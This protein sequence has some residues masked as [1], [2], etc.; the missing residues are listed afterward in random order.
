MSQHIALGQ[1]LDDPQF[2]GWCSELRSELAAL[3][4]LSAPARA[5]LT[6][7]ENKS[8]KHSDAK[9]LVN[10]LRAIAQPMDLDDLLRRLMAVEEGAAC[11]SDKP[12]ALLIGNTGCGKSTTLHFLGGVEFELRRGTDGTFRLQATTDQ[13]PDALTAIEASSRGV[14]KT[15]I[16]IP[17]ILEW[18]SASGEARSLHLC[19]SPG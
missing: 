9:K 18:V 11:I 6:K 17:V 19:D 14:S 7:L 2:A 16:I 13:I 1:V 4:L 12:V 10:N 3:D 5:A 8:T 15:K